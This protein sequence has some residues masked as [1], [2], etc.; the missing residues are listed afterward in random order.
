MAMLNNQRVFQWQDD[1]GWI[2]PRRPLWFPD[3]RKPERRN[4]KPPDWV[5]EPSGGSEMEIFM[6]LDIKWDFNGILIAFNW[7]PMSFAE[8]NMH[9]ENHLVSWDTL[10]FQYPVIYSCKFT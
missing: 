1:Y 7:D 2:L 9:S 10:H 3:P 5:R 4:L 6:G 8:S